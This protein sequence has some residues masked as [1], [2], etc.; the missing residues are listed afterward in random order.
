V[1]RQEAGG[2]EAWSTLSRQ[3][4]SGFFVLFFKEGGHDVQRVGS[5]LCQ[6]RPFAELDRF[7]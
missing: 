3:G 5:D 4:E 7:M 2:V 1:W 6:R